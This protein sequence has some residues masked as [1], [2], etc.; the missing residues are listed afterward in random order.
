[1]F[2][3]LGIATIC[4]PIMKTVQL[5]AMVLH[6]DSEEQAQDVLWRTL[7]ARSGYVILA[8]EDNAG[9]HAIVHTH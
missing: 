6:R 7:C 3:R 2:S 1:M 4:L 5:V 8:E 9:M